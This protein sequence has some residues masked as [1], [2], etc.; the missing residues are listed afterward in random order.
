MRPRLLALLASAASSAFAEEPPS[1]D[2][3]A[4]VSPAL[5]EIVVS[6]RR[7]DENLEDTPVS[8]TVFGADELAR[9]S[10]GELEEIAAFT[11]DLRASAGPQGGSAG[12]YFARGVGQLDFIA[13]TDPGVGVYVDGVYLGRTTGATFDL[14]DVDRVEVLRGP[15]G[16]L[17]GRNAI[18]G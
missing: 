2:G 7:R 4:R 14:L 12:Q 16:T 17:F 11:P 18:G 10:V 9:R 1:A 15:Q 3:V 13:S 8:V 5:E 6:A